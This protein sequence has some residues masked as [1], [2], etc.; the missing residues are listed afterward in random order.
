M[1][2]IVPKTRPKMQPASG[3]MR[4]APMMIGIN[5]K[6]GVNGP[7]F[8]PLATVCSTTMMA[9][10]KAVITHF[11]VLVFFMFFPPIPLP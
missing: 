10:N 7:I 4:M 6:V 3:L 2:T 9:A 5:D 1:K 8:I 11:L